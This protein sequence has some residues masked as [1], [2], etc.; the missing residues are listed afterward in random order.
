MPGL[1]GLTPDEVQE[2][3]GQ[4]IQANSL[5]Y[6][7][8]TPGQQIAAL[9]GTSGGLFGSAINTALG[10]ESPE[11]KKARLVQQ[12]QQETD[13]SGVKFGSPEYFDTAANN[14]AKYGLQNEALAAKKYGSDLLA[15]STKAGLEAEKLKNEQGYRREIAGAGLDE[16][17]IAAV[18]LKYAKPEIALGIM[19]KKQE[20]LSRQQQAKDA[21]EQKQKELDAKI[22]EGRLNREQKARA[23]ADMADL[24]RRTL[25]LQAE[26]QRSTL[27]LKRLQFTTQGDKQLVQQTQQLG[28][29]LEKANLPEADSVLTA[30][31]D[32]LK[33]RPG[34]AEYI[35][36]PKSLIPD[37][38]LSP[39]I[40]A[41]KQ[42]FQ[43][44]FNI[45]LK[46]RS[47]SAVT[48][49]ELERLKAEFAAGAFKTAAQLQKAVEQARNIINKHYSSVA[50][51]YG[52]E[53]LKAYNEN[54][55][56]LGGKVVI[57]PQ[58]EKQ[59]DPLGIR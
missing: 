1:F 27:D 42:A 32:T 10:G 35:S 3:M 45:T 6:A 21:L 58:D 49:Q 46:N 53:A 12:A 25:D 19:Q 8:L 51:G 36:G 7:Q 59:A 29:A 26:I 24:K 17:K 41:G 14:L 2:K 9:A 34:V 39:D 4:D 55:R 37:A 38:L 15:S 31:E 30:V 43:K 18:A 22:E 20:L 48:N 57:E 5:K 56:G 40:A 23:D 47:G 16:D 33:K 28:A 52:K 50:S 11:I 54:L 13:A 44:L